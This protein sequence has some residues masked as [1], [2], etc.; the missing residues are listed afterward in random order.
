MRAVY[1]RIGGFSLINDALIAALR[2]RMGG[3]EWREV[4]VERDIVRADRRLLVRATVEAVARYG[5]QIGKG[6][7]PPRDFCPRLPVVLR[8]VREWSRR[9]L[10]GYDFSVQTQSLFD[11]SCEGVPHFVYTDHTYLAN[12]RYAEPKAALPV[13]VAWREMERGLYAGARCTFVSSEFAAASVREDYGV[14]AE[15]VRNV[16]SG[17]NVDWA[18]PREARSGRRILFVGVDWERKGGPEL[19]RAFRG[20]RAEIPGAELEIVGCAPPLDAPGIFVRG[21]L[22]R[23]ETEACYR[24]ADVFCLPSR[25]DP[26]ASVLAEAAGFGLPVVATPVGGNVERV[27]EGE[28]GYL[29]ERNGLAAKLILLLRDGGLREKMGAAGR[30]MARR[31]F[32]WAAV[33]GRIAE[34]IET[35]LSVA[36]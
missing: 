14:M 9:E 2:E 30:E 27:V 26:A 11:A 3:V 24:A 8:A 31:Q 25:M 5:W 29:V 20:V 1:F 15:R 19:V 12:R 17:S 21:R 13:A 10:Q 16:G 6:R 7:V 18:G 34:R 22:S 23:A 35:E 4:D 36:T 28:T 33:A 32:T